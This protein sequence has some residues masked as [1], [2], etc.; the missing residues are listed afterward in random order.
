MQRGEPSMWYVGLD[1]ADTHHDV[2]ILDEAGKRV[3]A[4]RF[5]HSHQGLNELKAFLLS[6]VPS[7]EQLACVVETTH[8]LLITFLLEA[9]IPIYPVNPKTINKLRKAAG[10]KTDRIDAYLLAKTG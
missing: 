8:G 2:V 5:A 6:I 9:G 4:R 10:A 3:A 1:W 7:A